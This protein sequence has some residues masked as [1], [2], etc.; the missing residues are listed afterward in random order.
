MG[1]LVFFAVAF[2][3]WLLL[4]WTFELPRVVIG[5]VVALLVTF[6]Y[7]A[8]FTKE[9]GKFANPLRYLRLINYIPVFFYHCIKSNFDVLYRVIHPE[10]PIRPGIVKVKTSLKS[11]VARTFLANSITL[12]P[13]TMSVDVDGE[14]LYVHW[15]WVETSDEKEAT[16]L[17]PAKFERY[18]KGIF[19]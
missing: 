10:L 15:I 5:A 17:I 4:T 1:K 3:L 9:P 7:G 13:G 16:D 6:V 18:L 8:L 2:L 14:Y 11:D 19:E 12:T